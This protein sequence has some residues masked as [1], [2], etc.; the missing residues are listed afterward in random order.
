ML[1]CVYPFDVLTLQR[2]SGTLQIP[3]W[4]KH[5]RYPFVRVFARTVPIINFVYW[6]LPFGPA[7]FC[8]LRGVIDMLQI[9]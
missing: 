3:F 8:C 6:H 1:C 5:A 7:S 4:S 9:A 2:E